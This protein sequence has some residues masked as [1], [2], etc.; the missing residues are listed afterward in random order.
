MNWRRRAP[1]DGVA[2]RA[3]MTI[4][5]SNQAHRRHHMLLAPYLPS[6]CISAIIWMSG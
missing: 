2:A 5:F 4:G 6:N 3:A 1:D